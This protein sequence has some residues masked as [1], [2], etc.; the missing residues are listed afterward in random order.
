MSKYDVVTIGAAVLD[1]IVRSSE[2]KVMKSHEIEGGVALC[3]VYG[4]KTEVD[5]VDMTVGGGAT[6]TA[7]SLLKKGVKV[8]SVFKVADDDVG[9]LIVQHLEEEGLDLSLM[10]KAETGRSAISVVLLANQG[11]RSILTSRGVGKEIDSSEIEWKKLAK[12]EWL[13]IASLGGKMALIEDLIY[14]TK[15]EGVKVMWNPGKL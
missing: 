15:S 1:V 14:F 2:F 13:M 11:G 5:M 9:K 10:I 12:A 8:G 4:G 3:E 7:V 6:N